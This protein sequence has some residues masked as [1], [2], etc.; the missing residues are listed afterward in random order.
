MSLFRLILVTGTYQMKQTKEKGHRKRNKS[1]HHNSN[2]H[3]F[4][5]IILLERVYCASENQREKKTR[6]QFLS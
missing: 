6:M 3:L 2:M 4:I 1:C 5:K